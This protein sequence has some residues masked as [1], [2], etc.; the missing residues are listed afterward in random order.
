MKNETLKKIAN[1]ILIIGIVLTLIGAMYI[2]II[3]RAYAISGCFVI[4]SVLM[5]MLLLPQRNK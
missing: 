5:G 2:A 4:A 3:Q 1:I